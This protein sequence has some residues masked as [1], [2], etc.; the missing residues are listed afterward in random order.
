VALPSASFHPFPR[1]RAG[2]NGPTT[3]P[4]HP[5]SSYRTQYDSTLVL[6]PA[7]RVWAVPTI[8]SR[9]SVG[10]T[11][12]PLHG[13]VCSKGSIEELPAERQ[14]LWIDGTTVGQPGYRCLNF[15]KGYRS[16]P[17]HSVS[18]FS[19]QNPMSISWYMAL[20]VVR[21]SAAFA[22]SLVRR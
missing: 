16:I 7:G 20:A 22:R 10:I 12:A 9:P 3:R 19:S 13:M 17:S 5:Y 21:C 6:T 4:R 18:A 1:D 14:Q 11:G 2:L 15:W 8:P